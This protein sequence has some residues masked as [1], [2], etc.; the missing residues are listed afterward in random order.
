M[1]DMPIVVDPSV[2]AP[3]WLS[4]AI[5]R[6]EGDE[7][8][9]RLAGRLAPVAHPLAEGPRGDLLRGRWL[10]HALH[11]L[12]TDLPLGCWLSAGFL[13]LFGGRSS[14]RAAQRLVGLGLLT[15]PPTVASGLA[16]WHGVM[17]RRTRRVGV[18]HALGNGMVAVLYL[19]SWRSRRRGRQVRGVLWA[20]AGG[21]LAW[22]TGYLGG[23]L[24][25]GRGA[26]VG[27]RGIELAPGEPFAERLIAAPEAASLLQVPVEQVETLV[28]QGLLTPV[29][30]D[31]GERSFRESEVRAVRLLGG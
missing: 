2:S 20:L 8:I 13:D 6:I 14:R 16:D 26:G 29:D 9:D 4:E 31:G 19:R 7:R 3:S 15:V 5:S 17:D 28:D 1:T 30:H 23:H 11:P 24:S 21:L 25:F 22:V 10:G 12:L 27:I 18:V